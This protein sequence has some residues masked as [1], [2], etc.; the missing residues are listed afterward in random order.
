VTIIKLITGFY[1]PEFLLPIN[2]F[3]ALRHCFRTHSDRLIFKNRFFPRSVFLSLSSIS[4]RYP[5]SYPHQLIIFPL[6]KLFFLWGK[7]FL[8]FRLLKLCATVVSELSLAPITINH[9]S[10]SAQQPDHQPAL[11]LKVLGLGNRNL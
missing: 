3:S 10:A 4:A 2:N 1:I 6:L 5:F 7:F 11:D 8:F 9:I